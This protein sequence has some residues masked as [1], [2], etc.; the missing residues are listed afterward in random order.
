MFAPRPEWSLRHPVWV[1][2]GLALIPVVFT[3]AASAVAQIT[4]AGETQT[5]LITAAGVALSAIIGLVIMLIAR[6]S[7]RDFGFR[8]PRNIGRVLWFIPLLATVVIALVTG[9]VSVSSTTA[10]A[11][12]LLTVAVG[13]NEEVFFRGLILAA[14]RR[15]GDRKAIVVSAIL[16][17]VLHLAGLAGGATPLYAA[18]QVVFA[19]LFGLVAAQIVV[20]TGSLW[21]TIIWHVLYDTVSY[22]GGDQLTPV[23]IGGAVA[24]CVI[25]AAT[26]VILWRRI[27]ATAASPEA[28]EAGAVR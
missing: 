8:V 21:P 19:A 28:P 22:L 17:G 14:L 24:N 18:L 11:I 1:S 3:A 9:G 6:P 23:T 2:I 15:L 10:G 13:V 25:L 26:A 16:F 5:F 12:V 20:L 7:L 27:P 4:H